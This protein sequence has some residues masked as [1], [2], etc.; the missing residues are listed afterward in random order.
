MNEI[1]NLIIQE[2]EVIIQSDYF[3]DIS[4]LL[5]KTRQFLKLDYVE[6]MDAYDVSPAE[7]SNTVCYIYSNQ[8]FDNLELL[9]S[10]STFKENPKI[11]NLDEYTKDLESIF[12]KC[13]NMAR[14]GYFDTLKKYIEDVGFEN[15]DTEVELPMYYLE[16][17]LLGKG[18]F[19]IHPWVETD[20]QNYWSHSIKLPSFKKEIRQFIRHSLP[21]IKE[22]KWFD[23]LE[24]KTK[25][26]LV[27]GSNALNM[28]YSSRIED[29]NLSTID[30][31]S[32]LLPYVKAI[33]HEIT[34]ILRNYSD[35]LI[36]DSRIILEHKEHKIGANKN[37]NDGDFKQLL[38]LCGAIKE[39]TKKKNNFSIFDLYLIVKYFIADEDYNN[40]ERFEE[41]FDDRIKN[42]IL[43]DQNLYGEMKRWGEK[44]NVFVHAEVI[45]SENEFNNDY[46]HLFLLLKL[47]SQIKF[48]IS[49]NSN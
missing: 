19:T 3:E 16:F 15:P 8:V 14:L 26:I 21:D 27:M 43:R 45:A 4:Y 12:L 10:R 32:L 18:I 22:I 31:S 11:Y 49:E 39:D 17:S 5:K 30:Y 1:R 25:K 23:S 9:Y 36:K 28:F 29:E 6:S 24:E 47:I 35:K 7:F 33:E 38:N 2:L 48:M 46:N 34:N 40:L 41:I 13:I 37:N 44:R 42:L 20:L